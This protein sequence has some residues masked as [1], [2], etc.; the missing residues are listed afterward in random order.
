MD[1]KEG[2]SVEVNL[3][4]KSR[5]SHLFRHA[6]EITKETK[7]GYLVSIHTLS[8]ET[9]IHNILNNSLLLKND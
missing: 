8:E 7:G 2:Q 3:N 6:S 4:E 5:S 1:K 9:K